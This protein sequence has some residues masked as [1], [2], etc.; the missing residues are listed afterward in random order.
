[1]MSKLKQRLIAFL[2]KVNAYVDASAAQL[3]KE[4]GY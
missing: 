2:K 3:Y 4:R 1:M